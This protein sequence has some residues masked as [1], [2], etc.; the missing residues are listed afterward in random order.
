MSERKEESRSAIR[1]PAAA[2]ERAPQRGA[3]LPAGFSAVPCGPLVA[4]RFAAEHQ[5]AGASREVSIAVP[6][7]QILL[8]VVNQGDCSFMAGDNRTLPMRPNHVLVAD[9]GAPLELRPEPDARLSGLIMPVHL[10]VPRFLSPERLKAASHRSHAHSVAPLLC[11]FLRS[12]SASESPPPGP[13]VDAV[14]GMLSATLEDCDAAAEPPRGEIGRARMEQIDRHLLRHFAD[15][16]TCAKSVASA[17]G[18]SRRYLHKLFERHHRTFRAAL[19]DLRIDA[20]TRAFLDESQVDKSIAEIAFA[21]G[22]TD[23]SEFNRHF[24]RRHGAPP[25]TFR[26]AALAGIAASEVLPPAEEAR[27]RKRR[28]KDRQA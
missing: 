20:C 7:G 11:E 21:V 25:K 2:K 19:I 10:L 24:R 14:G 22:Y 18:V 6:R 13:A 5:N 26:R 4:I 3:A 17:V 27:P 9:A 12:F 28:N 8:L 1:A 15:P 16:Y 23:M